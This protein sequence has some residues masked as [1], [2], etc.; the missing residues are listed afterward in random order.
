MSLPVEHHYLHVNG[1]RFHVA[2][3]GRGEKLLLLLHG[4]PEFWWS[5]RHQIEA[6]ADRYTVVVPDLRGYNETEKPSWGYELDVLVHD[7]AELI[8]ALGF[9]RAYVAGHDWGGMI[10]WSLAIA[11]PHL[12]ERFIALNMPHPARFFE[13]LRRN[14][15]Q[16][17]RSWYIAFFQ[18]PWLAEAA[19]RARHGVA[20][21]RAFRATAID[22]QVFD[23]QT[24]RCYQQAIARPGALTAAL[25]YYR[26]MVQV[27]TRGLFRGTGMR[28]VAPT[29]LIWGEQ[30]ITFAP[31]VVRETGRFVPDLRIRYLPH[32]SHWVQQVAPDEVNAAMAEFLEE[33]VS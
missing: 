29:L 22:R 21:T 26:S 3:A 12:V 20:I 32:A 27:G 28:V 24:I 6:F 10:A 1:V 7:V 25:N 2:R 17:R 15:L 5:W 9:R 30:D 13:E 14:P 18:V 16:Q 11:R 19:L 8:R 31:E 4:F 33:D 23:E